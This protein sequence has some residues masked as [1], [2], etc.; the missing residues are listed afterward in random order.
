MEI[1]V[2]QEFIT[3]ESSG[4]SLTQQNEHNFITVSQTCHP[5]NMKHNKSSF[6]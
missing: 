2:V 3:E 5:Q 6:L 4:C 1:F